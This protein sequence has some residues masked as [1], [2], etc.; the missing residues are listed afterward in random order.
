MD[1]D[2]IDDD[3]KFFG[4]EEET[5][6][7]PPRPTQAKGGFRKILTNIIKAAIGHL[8]FGLTVV[9]PAHRSASYGGPPGRT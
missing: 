6:Q 2:D 8:H 9:I 7:S 3:G 5:K 4:E 1:L